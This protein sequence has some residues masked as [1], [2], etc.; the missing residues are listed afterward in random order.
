MFVLTPATRWGY[1]A[2]PL[3]LL[4]WLALTRRERTVTGNSASAQDAVESALAAG[5]RT[6]AMAGMLASPG[7][8]KTAPAAASSGSVS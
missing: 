6:S 4:G 3:G 7:S 2:Y 8:V 5:G 1:F